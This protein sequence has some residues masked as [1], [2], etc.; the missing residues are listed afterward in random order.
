MSKYLLFTIKIYS[1]EGLKDTLSASDTTTTRG[2][3]GGGQITPKNGWAVRPAPHK[4]TLCKTTIC[5]FS[6]PIYDLTKN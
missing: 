4:F 6:N 2:G 1:R 3:G 5:D